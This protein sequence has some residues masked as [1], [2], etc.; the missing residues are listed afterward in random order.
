MEAYEITLL[1]VCLCVRPNVSR[2]RLGKHFLAATNTNAA[3]EEVLDAMIL[4]G[5]CRIKYSVGI[6]RKLYY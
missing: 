4:C 5:L 3:I 6:E 2:Q 1:Y